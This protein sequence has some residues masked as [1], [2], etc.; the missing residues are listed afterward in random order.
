MPTRR[1]RP[2]TEVVAEAPR[3]PELSSNRAWLMER[4]SARMAL[5]VGVS[6]FVLFSIG[7]ELEPATDQSEP[8]VGIL[9]GTALIAMFVA[10]LVG[11]GMRRRWGLVTSLGAAVTLTAMSIMCPVSGHHSFGA[12]WYGQ[13]LCALALVGISFAALRRESPN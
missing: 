11:L 8:F 9:L 3:G 12:W 7:A 5:A 2:E 1:P 10:T 6:W 4:I 13:M